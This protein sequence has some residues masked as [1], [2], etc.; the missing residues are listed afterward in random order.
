MW[1][2]RRN[3]GM[4]EHHGECRRRCE[5]RCEVRAT[6][7]KG[8]KNVRSEVR[9][10]RSEEKR[11]S[12]VRLRRRRKKT[13]IGERRNVP[14]RSKEREEKERA[15]VW[16]TW[17]MRSMRDSGAKRRIQEVLHPLQLLCRRQVVS[18]YTINYFAF[19]GSSFRT[20][21]TYITIHRY[22]TFGPKNKTIKKRK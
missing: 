12:E 14:V 8:V 20:E 6:W 11:L 9:L 13:Y 2:G 1:E 21:Q 17:R 7:W 4:Q 15:V 18:F 5:K 3:C 10:R 22:R 19:F 16:E